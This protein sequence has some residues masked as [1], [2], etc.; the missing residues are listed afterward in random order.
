MTQVKHIPESMIYQSAEYRTLKSQFSVLY[1]E[2]V[3]MKQV[4][5]ESR[6]MLQLTRNNHLRRIEQLEVRGAIGVV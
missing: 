3:Q 2:S 4:L 6:T 5:D 1:N